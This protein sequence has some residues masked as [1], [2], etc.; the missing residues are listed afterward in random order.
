MVT[1][2]GAFGLTY[3]AVVA[4]FVSGD[5]VYAL[6]TYRWYTIRMTADLNTGTYK[7]Y[8][9]GSELA[10]ITD[11]V[12]PANVNVDF[13]RLGAASRGDSV[14][15]TY[16]DDVTVS[17]LGPSPPANQW[18]VSIASSLGGSTSL[19][20]TTNVNVGESLTVNASHKRGLCFQQV[21]SR[22]R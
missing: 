20:G 19:V 22:R 2:G 11:I 14:F 6:E 1:E 10:S 16:Y 3:P 18:S 8:M 17:F 5:V 12:V 9:D 13:F 21:D 7:M 15:I 4:G